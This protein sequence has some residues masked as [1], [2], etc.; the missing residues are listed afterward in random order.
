MKPGPDGWGPGWWESKGKRVFKRM[1]KLT[2][3]ELFEKD[4]A[5][6]FK[7]EAERG[8]WFYHEVWTKFAEKTGVVY[9]RT[10]AQK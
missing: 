5:K 10:E 2:T 3:V 6:E 1:E 4:R 7:S 8:V 9:T